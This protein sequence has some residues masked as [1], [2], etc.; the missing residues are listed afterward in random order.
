VTIDRP[1]IL[2]AVA[3]LAA[4][5][6]VYSVLRSIPVPDPFVLVAD[7]TPNERET[8]PPVEAAGPVPEAEVA[9]LPEL[10]PEDLG[11]VAQ[12][13]GTLR[14]RD[15]TPVP[16]EA[17]ELSS[18]AL[19][20]SYGATS[21]ARGRFTIP[22][23]ALG[24]DYEV[25]VSSEGRYRDVATRGLAVTAEGVRLDLVL[26]PLAGARLAGR[27]VDADGVPIASRTLLLQGSH[28][29]GQ[30]LLVT[31]DERGRFWLDD[32]PTGQ[33]TF[34]TR[35]IPHIKVRGPLLT[36]ASQADV[37]LVLDEGSHE[38]AG[39]VVGDR[40]RPVAGA[41]LKLSWT[42]KQGDSISSSARTAVTDP[43]GSFRFTDL[44]PGP[45]QLAVRADGYEEAL[46]TYGVFWN[47]GDVE[48]R[49]RPTFR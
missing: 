7:R 47:S 33:L 3:T 12:V 45:H 1:T 37:T 38:F 23:V 34:S 16:D 19:E 43:S 25:R 2:A 5:V 32:A 44:G 27:M 20:A 41:Q 30:Q 21:D 9:S 13:A 49:L 18:W 14:T 26:E 4:A 36:P 6:P 29:P 8:L 39:R 46:E 31:G 10:E 15:G 40:D 17:V 35:T 42:H 24:S 48:L 11:P 22:N 28:E